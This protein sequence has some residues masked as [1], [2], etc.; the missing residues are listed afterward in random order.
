[1]DELRYRGRVCKFLGCV[2]SVLNR[3]QNAVYIARTL[4]A[5]AGVIFPVMDTLQ[6]AGKEISPTETFVLWKAADANLRLYY[7][8]E[9]CGEI[10]L[11][12]LSDTFDY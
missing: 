12:K 4:R 10:I 5:L 3:F 2:L 7:L 11:D 9:N 1:M 6:G 8:Y